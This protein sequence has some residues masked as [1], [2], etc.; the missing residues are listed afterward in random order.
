MRTQAVASRG[1]IRRC[2]RRWSFHATFLLV[3]L[4]GTAG[5]ARG[6]ESQGPGRSPP[7]GDGNAAPGEAAPE[8]PFPDR[9]PAPSLDG[10]TEWLNTASEI[11]LREL[12]GKVVVLDFWTYCCIN[13]M[14]VLPDLKFLEKKYA[15]Q[16][17]VIGVHVGKFDNE[18]DPENI[19]RAILRYE[20]EHPVVND[21]N[22]VIAEKYR[23]SSWPTLAVIDPEGRYIGRQPGEG[24]R[25]LFD[26]V[27]GRIVEYHRAKGTLDETPV[28]FDLER[29]KAPSGPLKFPGK[30]IADERGNR[31]FVSDSN[32]N[33]IVISTLDGRLVDVVG[34]GGIGFSNGSFGQATF[35]HPQGMVLV[36]ETL[37]VADTENH[38]IRAV[39]LAARTVATLAGTGA[40]SQTRLPGGPVRTT[41]LNSPWDLQ[42]LDGTLYIAM[43]GPHQLWQHRLG[44]ETIGVFAGTGRED[45]LDGPRD[46][47]ALA[48]PSGITTDGKVLYHVD[49][50][51]S[52]VR[53]VTL[54]DEGDVLTVVGPHDIPQGRSLFEFG[55]IDGTGDDARLQHPLGIVYH[56][57][58][59]YVADTYNHKIRRIDPR[60]RECITWLGTGKR[61]KK[62]DPVELSEPAGLAVAGG[63]LLIADTNNHRILAT[64]LQSR[65]TSEFTIAGLQPAPATQGAPAE[66]TGPEAV[67]V[68]VQRVKSGASLRFSIAFD[69]PEGFKLNQLG[70]VTYTLKATGEQSLVAAEELNVRREAAKGATGATIDVPL[71]RTG[72]SGT[73]ELALSYSYCR[74]GAGGV[75]RLAKQAWRLPI[76]VSPDAADESLQLTAAPAR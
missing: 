3:I 21:S 58:Y 14:H 13:C 67:D 42:H 48:Q 35:D 28:R 63:R 54:G 11:S 5:V 74:S 43:A 10:G 50:E 7:A 20:I 2:Q 38:A 45:I 57:G 29:D 64:D 75:C 1:V 65:R 16:L 15:N 61:G 31:L 34:S 62:L 33:R 4:A 72:G 66:T 49:S 73:F 47:C 26:Q 56:G 60:T 37:Y 17:V 27:I 55:D 36:E 6:Q 22:M 9:L 69:L 12:R 52:A 39:D 25:E 76:E 18:K 53:R 41:P 59:L 46:Y 44:G 23:F 32:H 70:P 19:R 30:I 40:Q 8:N 71:T 24:N 51:G 68:A